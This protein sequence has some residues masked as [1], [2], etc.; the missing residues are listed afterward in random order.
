MLYPRRE[1]RNRKVIISPAPPPLKM[2]E[3]AFLIGNGKYYLLSALIAQLVM[4]GFLKSR[5]EG[6][7]PVR[8][9]F[10]FG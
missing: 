6:S 10:F 9:I 8:A 4:K 5:V 7:I 3:T 2:A 1:L